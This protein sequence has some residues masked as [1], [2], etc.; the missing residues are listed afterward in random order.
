MAQLFTTVL[1][2]AQFTVANNNT[3]MSLALGATT[4]VICSTTQSL[5]FNGLTA[6]TGNVDGMVATIQ[7]VNPA[8]SFSFTFSHDGSSPASSGFLNQANA[9]ITI[10]SRFGSATFRYLSSQARWLCIGKA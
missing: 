4:M 2:P 9:P 8:G 3:V 6:A 10:G 5:T 7:L 1:T